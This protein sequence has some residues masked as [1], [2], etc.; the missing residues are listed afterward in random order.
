MRG[1]AAN[2]AKAAGSEKIF[3]SPRGSSPPDAA[4]DDVPD[5]MQLFI[6]LKHVP[7]CASLTSWRPFRMAGLSSSLSPVSYA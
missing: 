3:P 2:F 4:M 1:L 5:S 7:F 6:S